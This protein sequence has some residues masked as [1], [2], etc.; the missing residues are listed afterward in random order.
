MTRSTSVSRFVITAVVCLFA[1]T[2]TTCTHPPES[3]HIYHAPECI[4]VPDPPEMTPE[5]PFEMDHD[6]DGLTPQERLDFIRRG[7]AATIEVRVRR[8]SAE[9]GFT[10]HSGTGVFINEHQALTA[11]HVVHD[12]VDRIAVLRRLVSGGISIGFLRWERVTVEHANEGFDVALLNIDCP[13]DMAEPLPIARGWVPRTDELVWQF[14]N[15]T[16]WSRGRVVRRI[17]NGIP[18]FGGM[19]QTRQLG[20]CGDSGGPVVNTN[21]ELVGL[22]LR[23]CPDEGRQFFV[24]IDNALRAVGLA[25]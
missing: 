2:A 23:G 16:G 12:T 11:E 18:T 6:S 17:P 3:R 25:P 4:Y 10:F 14:G 9:K 22:T 8:Y 13:V 19:V 21:G 1:F 24:T 5:D 20:Q 15:V 7:V